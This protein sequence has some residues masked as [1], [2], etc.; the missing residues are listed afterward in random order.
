M[1]RAS[2]ATGWSFPWGIKART[3]SAS[4]SVDVVA[5]EGNK[6]VPKEGGIATV[7][8]TVVQGGK[9]LKATT[10][11]VVVPFYRDHQQALVLKLLLGM[12]GQPVERLAKELVAAIPNHCE[13][14][15]RDGE[16]SCTGSPAET[17]EPHW[18]A[19]LALF[20]RAEIT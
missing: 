2:P 12:E 7:E 18:S 8:A 6:V 9:R 16:K 20:R 10:E 11:V 14:A 3:K 4:G 19:G 15:D 13:C 5:I 17:L 1:P